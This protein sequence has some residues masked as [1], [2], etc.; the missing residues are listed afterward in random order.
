[1]VCAIIAVWS[2]CGEFVSI[3]NHDEVWKS[4]VSSRTWRRLTG[5]VRLEQ[6]WGHMSGRVKKEKRKETGGVREGDVR[7]VNTVSRN[8]TSEDRVLE[9]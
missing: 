4:G 2:A 9:Q 7:I 8:S 3:D 1:M 5:G 6:G